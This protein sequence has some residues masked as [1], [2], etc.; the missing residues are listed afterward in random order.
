MLYILTIIVFVYHQ[1]LRWQRHLTLIAS[2]AT[3]DLSMTLYEGHVLFDFA[4]IFKIKIIFLR[5][6]YTAI[7]IYIEYRWR[8][9]FPFWRCLG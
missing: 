1:R 2:P 5:K 4:F 3:G 9:L 8:E 7:L 6:A